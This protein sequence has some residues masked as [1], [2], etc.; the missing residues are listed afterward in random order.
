MRAFAPLGHS[1][2]AFA[3]ISVLMTRSKWIGV[4]V[5]VHIGASLREEKAQCFPARLSD[6]EELR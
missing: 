1:S 2:A 4:A 6:R 5:P 3:K